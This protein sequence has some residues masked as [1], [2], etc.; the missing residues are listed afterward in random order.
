MLATLP[1]VQV[2]LSYLRPRQGETKN[3]P[4]DSYEKFCYA[5]PS[6]RFARYLRS[7][8]DESTNYKRED[9]VIFEP[10]PMRKWSHW[11]SELSDTYP[12]VRGDISLCTKITIA[13]TAYSLLSNE[14]PS[15]ASLYRWPTVFGRNRYIQLLLA[16]RE[17]S[18]RVE[19][20]LRI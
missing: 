12:E 2:P 14:L 7:P 16:S 18:E 19:G 10:D 3:Q 15:Q 1:Y 4:E 9:F 8:T 6:F 5:S 13:P 17:E 20:L 11:K